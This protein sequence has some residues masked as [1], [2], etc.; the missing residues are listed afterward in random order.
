MDYNKNDA[1][2]VG[3]IAQNLEYSHESHKE[4]FYFTKLETERTSGKIDTI[5]IV[6]SERV[7]SPSTD[8]QGKIVGIRGQFRS[9]N[10]L[11]VDGEKRHLLLFLFANEIEIEDDD[12]YDFNQIKIDGYVCKHPTYRKTPLGREIS[13]V[14]IA[15][16][17]SYKKSDYIPCIFWGRNARWT[18]KLPVGTHIEILG[19]IQS[20]EYQKKISDDMHESRTAYEV[21]VSQMEVLDVESED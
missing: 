20:R 9:F 3:R 4:K 13:D 18:S 6:I 8:I 15:V 7:I 19:R 5:L 17:R 16:N 11:D 14:L 21:S 2:V 12:V 1:V 10:N